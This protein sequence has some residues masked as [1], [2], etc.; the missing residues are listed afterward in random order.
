[1]KLRIKLTLFA[2]FSLQLFSYAQEQPVVSGTVS[3]GSNV[4]IPGANVIVVGTNRGVYTNFDGKFTINAVKGEVLQFSYVGYQ[5]KNITISDNTT[6]SIVLEESA[7]ELDEVVIIGY[8]TQK[9]SHL[10]GAISKVVNED[11]D[12]IAVSRVDDALVGQVSGVNIQATE[13]EAGSAPTIRVRGTASIS[14]ALSPLI[15]V[16]GQVVG[17]D[18]LGAL[19]MNSIESFEVLKDAA[20]TAIY[21]SRG[22]RGVIMITTKMGKEGKTRFTYNTYTGYKRARQS[23]AYYFSVNESAQAELVATGSL[24]DRTK[25]KQQIGIDEDWQDIIFT[26]GIITSHSIGARGGSKNTKFSISG[27]YTHDEGVLLKDDFKK[28]N[29]TLK[30]DTKVSDLFS[31]GANITPTFTYKDR[32]D[33][34]THD[35]LRQAPWLPIYHDANTIQYVNRD[36][37]PDVQIG[38]YAVQRHFDDYDLYGNGSSV[39]ISSTSNTNPAAKILERDRTEDRFKVYGTVYGQFN[40][41]KDLSF[42]TVFSGDFQN[43]KNRRWQGV[44]ASRNGAAA[45]QLDISSQNVL[46]L[47]T[48]NYLTFNKMF[49]NHEVTAVAGVSSETWDTEYESVRG[50]G[51]DSDLLQTITAATTISL[52]QSEEYEKRL[53]SLFGRLN[54]AYKDKYLL[55]LSL[56][57]DGNS[58]LGPNNK[59]GFF[60]AASVGWNVARENFLR[61]SDVISN[62]KFRFSY[63]ITGNES[64]NTGSSL[65]DNYP[66]LALL[67]PST[68]VVGGSLVS[69][70]NPVNIANPDLQWERTKEINPGVDFGFF[71]NRIAG[72]FEYYNKESDKLILYNPVSTTTGFSNALVNL[73]EV[74][75]EG[76]ELELTTRNIISSDFSWSTTIIGSKNKNTLVDFADSDGQILSVDS[77]RAAEW[78]N[79][80]GEPISSFYGWVVDEEISPEHILYPYHPVGAQASG[81]YVKDLNGD[82]LIDNDDRTI[83]GNPYPDLLWSVTNDVKIGNFDFSFMFQGSHG[84]QVRNMADQYLFNHFNSTQ[85]YD[86]ATTPNQGFI[87]EKIFTN[88]IIQDASYVALR[89]VNIGYNFP[90]DFLKRTKVF[91]RARIYAS[92]Q[93]LMYL[94]EDDYTGFNPESI[95]RTSATTYGYQ[96]GGSPIFSTISLGLN[97]EF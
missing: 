5:T 13:G 11:L 23:D 80:E 47:T 57:R 89:N 66:Y 93:N 91:T 51:Y 6:Y 29:L 90:R 32:F 72:S 85:Q 75:N 78:I 77:K 50:T 26:G 37:Y 84:A 2:L 16:D 40:I 15:V 4:P 41:T 3:D 97:L 70:F 43:A 10:T 64:F 63:G 53:F 28:Y 14:G 62:L 55:S 31:F 94:T 65:I 68:A 1:M 59:Y 30:I 88:S 83:L 25:Y 74:R 82:G 7:S 48:Q 61:N 92:G 45:A 54:Y 86:P 9:K 58:A 38:D 46:H 79:L 33:G 20:S 56:R 17:N 22:S 76:Y 67:E 21:G 52:A 36:V 95:R 73:G 96:L 87:R 49:N 18:Y 81:V 35:I 8:G 34:S 44:Q 71:G 27:N 69:A 19:D 12:Q 24:S 39:S 60:P 42:K